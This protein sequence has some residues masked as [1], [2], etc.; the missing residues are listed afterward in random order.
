MFIPLPN[1]TSRLEIPTL[2]GIS[3]PVRHDCASSH[4][5][6]MD[7]TSKSAA[8]D[9]AWGSS[10]RAV[11]IE[12]TPSPPPSFMHNGFPGP[13]RALELAPGRLRWIF[14]PSSPFECSPTRDFNTAGRIWGFS[15][16]DS[17]IQE[18]WAT[19]V[20]WPKI[21]KRSMCPNHLE[22]VSNGIHQ[23]ASAGP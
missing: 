19:A 23:W 3:I 16:R 6:M 17:H 7:R 22:S 13:G 2:A 10:T 5:I 9:H 8:Q 20:K 12:Q 21:L 1:K 18:G 11:T 4:G 15:F 14:S